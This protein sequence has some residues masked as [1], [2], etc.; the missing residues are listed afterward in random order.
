MVGGDDEGVAPGKQVVGHAQDGF[1]AALAPLVQEDDRARGDVGA[2]PAGD[3]FGI[4]G[5]SVVSADTPADKTHGA[6]SERRLEEDVF[7]ADGR[8]E[9]AQH[10]DASGEKGFVAGID[11]PAKASR[12]Q[13]PEEM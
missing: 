2:D 7:D 8:A 11:L 12:T 1:V 3:G 5:D 4:A 10:G 6:L 9:P 13:R